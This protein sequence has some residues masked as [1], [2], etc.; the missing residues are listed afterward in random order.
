MA[1][2]QLPVTEAVIQI[3]H[4]G[5]FDGEAFTSTLDGSD[6]GPIAPQQVFTFDLNTYAPDLVA[7]G[8]SAP[9]VGVFEE[10]TGKRVEADIMVEPELITIAFYQPVEPAE[11]RVKV[12]G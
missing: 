4:S 10:A 11:Y 2:N 5:E 9:F 8:V 3:I 1:L 12:I 7:M 6:G